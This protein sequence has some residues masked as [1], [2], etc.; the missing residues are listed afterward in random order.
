MT[1]VASMQL[2]P[3][4]Q[5]LRSVSSVKCLWLN[6]FSHGIFILLKDRSSVSAGVRISPSLI[7]WD[8]VGRWGGTY[9]VSRGWV[10][11]SGIRCQGWIVIICLRWLWWRHP[12]FFWPLV[13]GPLSLV[14]CGTRLC[15]W[16]TKP[17]ECKSHIK[18]SYTHTHTHTEGYKETLEVLNISLTL[19]AVIVFHVCVYMSKPIK[20][21]T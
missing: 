10:G 11:P 16:L 8:R 7:F 3:Y 14:M 9:A 19:I 1:S 18:C 6:L 2:H 15:L 5:V 12:C 17:V 13:S 4:T 21:H 20:L